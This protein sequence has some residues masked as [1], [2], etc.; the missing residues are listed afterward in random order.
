MFQHSTAIA[1]FSLCSLVA[2]PA[3]TAQPQDELSEVVLTATRNETPLLRLTMPVL[4]IERAEIEQ[5]QAQDVAELLDHRAGIEIARNGGPGQP[6]SIFM[7]GTESNHTAVLVDGVRI[8]PGTIGGAALQN[9]LPESIERIEVVKG[10]RSTLYGTDAIGGVINLITRAGN[11]RGATASLSA[12]RYD[13]QQY[14]LDGGVQLSETAGLGGNLAFRR[15]DGFPPQVNATEPG[16]YD[17]LSANLNGRWQ[18]GEQLGLRAV[19]WH[20]EGNSEYLGYDPF[21]NFGALDQDYR[22]AVY[23][24]GTDYRPGNLRLRLDLSQAEDFIDQNQSGDF[25]HTRRRTADGQIGW[26]PIPSNQLSLGVVASRE[27]TA[28]ESFGTAFDVTTDVTMLY[29]QDQLQLGASELLL[30]LG[31]TNHEAFGTHDSWNAEYGLAF[32]RGWRVTAAAGTA[33]HAPDS[34]D[35]FGYGG[36]PLLQPESSRQYELGLRWAGTTQ[37]AQLQVFEN[38]IDDLILFELVDPVNFVYRNENVE[39]AR[40][41]GLEASYQWQRGPWQLQGSATLQDPLNLTTGDPLL[42]RARQHYD[43]RIQHE[44]GALL[45]AGDL[46]YSGARYD[47]SFPATVRLPGYALLDLAAAWQISPRWKLQLRLDN[48]LDRDYTLVNGYNTPR[49]SVTIATRFQLQEF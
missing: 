38:R 47:S 48:A 17:N 45:L 4:V 12:S 21:F 39:R 42:R 18:P 37:Q 5:S 10:A 41:R 8:N 23:A 46:S 32:A 29:L 35:R 44:A 25:A 2:V 27:D 40:I 49:R 22:N 15:S 19:L 26:Q 31:N 14:A 1:V 3:G 9:V 33:F 28:A 43:L 16:G 34:T 20:A 13:T 11:A 24:L 6:A 36:N 30:A 7:R